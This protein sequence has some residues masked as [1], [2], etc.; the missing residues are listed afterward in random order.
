MSGREQRNPYEELSPVELTE[1]VRRDLAAAGAEPWIVEE[2]R[3]LSERI[4]AKSE[5]LDASHE[6]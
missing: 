3:E 1:Q 6:S 4:R 2:A 5:E